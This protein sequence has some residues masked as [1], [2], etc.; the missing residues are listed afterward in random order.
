MFCKARSQSC[1]RSVKILPSV[2][3]KLLEKGLADFDYILYW[4]ILRKIVE[5]LQ[6]LFRADILTMRFQVLTAASVKTV[7][8]FWDVAPCSW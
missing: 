3:I 1:G 8:V 7:I 5:P 6:F 4:R 2:R